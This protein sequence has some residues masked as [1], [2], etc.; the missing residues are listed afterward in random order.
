MTQ[1]AESFQSQAFRTSLV[2]IPAIRSLI[3]ITCDKPRDDVAPSSFLASSRRLSTFNSGSRAWSEPI[4][5]T[6]L[7]KASESHQWPIDRD[8]SGPIETVATVRRASFD[9]TS[10]SS[11]VRIYTPQHAPQHLKR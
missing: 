2:A 10:T 5:T 6:L 1:A 9:I 4:P 8:L 11:G 7:F 3:V